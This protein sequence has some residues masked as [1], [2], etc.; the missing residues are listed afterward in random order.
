[1]QSAAVAEPSHEL[2]ATAYA[3]KLAEHRRIVRNAVSSRAS[4][5]RTVLRRKLMREGSCPAAVAQWMHL[6][7]NPVLPFV[8]LECARAA[9]YPEMPMMATG[10]PGQLALASNDETAPMTLL[11]NLPGG[12]LKIEFEHSQR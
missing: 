3:E 5:L 12:D 9:G 4:V 11:E 2:G 10:T 7:P 1:V 8:Q 6:H